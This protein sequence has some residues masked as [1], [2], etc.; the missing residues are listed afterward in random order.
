MPWYF[1]SQTTAKSSSQHRPL[2]IKPLGRCLICPHD[3]ND[4]F[5][6][7]FLALVFLFNDVSGTDSELETRM[8]PRD[9]YQE[10]SI[11]REDDDQDSSLQHTQKNSPANTSCLRDRG[12]SDEWIPCC[13][14]FTLLSLKLEHV[15]FFSWVEL[16]Q[17]V[18][19]SQAVELRK[20]TITLGWV[21]RVGHHGNCDDI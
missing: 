1:A 2:P 14:L 17:R 5:I 8:W 10:G 16:L 15:K 4:T 12:T 9:L 13:L 6:H 20:W 19:E 11:P 18:L 21:G 7:Y 3:K